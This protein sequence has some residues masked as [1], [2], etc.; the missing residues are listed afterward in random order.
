[1]ALPLS[2]VHRAAALTGLALISTFWI[3]TVVVE[4]FG[5]PAQ[6]ALVKTAIA[7][8]LPVLIAA[9]AAA[10]IT[11][12]RM[13]AGMKGPVVRGKRLRTAF[14]AGN[15]FV[16]L[17]PSA[18]LLALMANAGRFDAVF[19]GVQGVELVAGAVNIMLLIANA[20][21]GARLKRPARPA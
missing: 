1:M 4:L 15:A 14:M 3:S 21:A 9:L 13:A 10:G 18:V 5:A 19:Y 17:I 12:R 7:F 11:G 2:T 20:R 16:V 6:I 8:S